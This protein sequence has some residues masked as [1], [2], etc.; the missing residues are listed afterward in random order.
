MADPGVSV[1]RHLERVLGLVAPLAPV[2]VP[3]GDAGGLVC[4][5]DVPAPISLP[6]FDHAAMDGYAVRAA[7]VADA[8]PAT[9]V[10]LPVAGV[11]AAGDAAQPTLVPGTAWR[12]M[13]GA[14]VPEG[15]DAV[16]PFEW[17]DRGR[18]TVRIDAAV[19]AARHVR[20][21]GEDVGE[22]RVAVAGGTKLAPRHL[23]L[24]AAVGTATVA[25]HPPPR[26]AVVVTGQELAVPDAELADL[27]AHVPD[28]NSVALAAAARAA[29]A[30]VVSFGP[31]PDDPQL[32]LDQLAE[33]AE[34]ADLV[35]TTG[36]VSAGDHDVVKAALRD[37]EG[38]WFG[39]VAVKPGRPQ[40]AGAVT[41][42]GG[43][44][45]PVVSLPGTPVAA[46]SSFRLFAE[47]AI[48]AL[49]GQSPR[50]VGRA[51][52]EAPVEV[53]ADRTLV[54]PA[55]YVAPGRVAQLAGHVGHSQRLLAA[56]DVLLVVPP[57][58]APLPAGAEVVILPL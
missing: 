54:L 28:S 9:P 40:G 41:A 6:R 22:G 24:L 7:D 12:I 38:F 49:A 5:A 47:P 46:Y 57:G 23:A 50:A 45:V 34:V 8:A 53:A 37:R 25:V 15:A 2:T 35:V 21:A 11:V 17:T 52:L 3:I 36:G 42:T 32:L 56:A 48:R 31:V 30:R 51:L 19:P 33:A 55:A 1:E 4:P 43:R 20:L 14:P 18:E 39:S 58:G 29:G 44:Q 10:V 16:V 13:T 26:V 27:P